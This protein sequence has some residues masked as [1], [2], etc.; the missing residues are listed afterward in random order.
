MISM[1][2]LRCPI[3]DRWFDGEQ[4]TSIPFCSE[5]C[6]QIDLSRWLNEKYALPVVRTQEV[7][8]EEAPPEAP[9]S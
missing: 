5:R 3:C 1:T 7:D 4:S 2:R 8:E 6:R 9:E